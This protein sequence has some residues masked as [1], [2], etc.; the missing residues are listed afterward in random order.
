VQLKIK[1]Q[2]QFFIIASAKSL[3]RS[4]FADAIYRLR[5]SSKRTQEELSTAALKR[6][7][8]GP[9]HCAQDEQIIARTQSENA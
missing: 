2:K 8:L 7:R 9:R 3:Q 1:N 4:T 5:H 6:T